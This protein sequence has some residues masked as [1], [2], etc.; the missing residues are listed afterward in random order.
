MIAGDEL[1]LQRLIE[2]TQSTFSTALG[3][4]ATETGIALLAFPSYSNVGDMMIWHGVRAHMKRLGV[5]IRY[6]ADH[7]LFDPAAIK[8]LDPEVPLV[9]TGGGNFGDIWPVFHEFRRML[10]RSFRDRGIIQLPQSVWYSDKD[11]A[12]SDSALFSAHPDFTMLV[13]DTQSLERVNRLMPAVRTLLCPDAA[14]GLGRLEPS[15]RTGES[16]IL[17]RHDPEATMSEREDLAGLNGRHMDWGL[18]GWP[19]VAWKAARLPGKLYGV[20]PSSE[21]ELLYPL[22]NASYQLMRVLNLGPGAQPFRHAPAVLTDRLHAHVLSILL[23]IP[24][25]VLDNSYGKISA[26]YQDWTHV[27]SQARFVNTADAA[28]DAFARIRSGTLASA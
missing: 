27:F 17:I 1:A 5:P 9:I 10:V 16:I 26:T 19:R 13:R 24:H 22:V 25:V 6:V 12:R 4:S 20:A 8:R 21:R 18:T 28:V 7:I 11:E 2:Q 23:D 3:P 15:D 14:F